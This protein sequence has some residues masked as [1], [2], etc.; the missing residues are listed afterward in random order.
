MSQRL[1]NPTA[2]FC[3][4][5]QASEEAAR[6]SLGESHELI[7]FIFII[8]SHLVVLRRHLRL[9][10]LRHHLYLPVLHLRR[11][12]RQRFLNLRLPQLLPLRRLLRIW[13]HSRHLLGCQS[14]ANAPRQHISL[15][16]RIRPHS[17]LLTL[18][19]T[20]SAP[21]ASLAWNV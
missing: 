7:S 15:T 13:H 12:H 20:M 2:T 5:S 16:L 1:W 10:H 3:T 14:S 21:A 6:L 9:L 8:C 17:P 18:Q 4:T 11:R 19:L